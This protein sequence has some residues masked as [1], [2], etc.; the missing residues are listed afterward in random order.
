ML[1]P[2]RASYRERRPIEW[3]RVHKLPD[4]VKFDHSIHVHKGIGCVSCHGRVDRMPLTWQVKSLHMDWCLD[5]HRNPAEH[6]RPREQVF[7][8]ALERLDDQDERGPELVREYGIQNKTSCSVC[9]R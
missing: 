4:F 8:L 9:H 2:V 6:V 1:E 3:V 5:C 7:N